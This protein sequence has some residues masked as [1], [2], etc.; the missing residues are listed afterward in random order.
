M[1]PTPPSIHRDQLGFWTPTRARSQAQKCSELG[2]AGAG[3]WPVQLDH[4]GS[5]DL[6]KDLTSGDRRPEWDSEGVSAS[7]PCLDLLV[8]ADEA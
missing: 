6:V 3:G 8:A 5:K 4:D 2:D 1:I 7:E